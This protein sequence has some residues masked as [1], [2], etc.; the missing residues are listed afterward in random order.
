MHPV[1]EKLRSQ[2]L[3]VTRES[4]GI[5]PSGGIRATSLERAPWGVL[6]ETGY[7]EAVATLVAYQ[8]GSASLYFST[9]GGMIGGGDHEA[10]RRAASAM[11]ARAAEFVPG[12]RATTDFPLPSPGR[13][14]F[15]VLADS[16]VYTAEGDETA[17][18]EERDPL[19]PLFYAGQDLITEFRKL[20]PA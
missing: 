7:P 8:D 6:M 5:A 16:G 15:Y 11:V 4:L 2:A 12:M 18:G 9:G 10:V 19:A 20:D 1:Y 17:M 3:A 14:V 13:T